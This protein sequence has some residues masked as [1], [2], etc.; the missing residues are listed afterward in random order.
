MC[1]N[2]YILTHLLQ[3]ENL[4]TELYHLLVPL[5]LKRL[6]I[7]IFYYNFIPIAK[8]KILYKFLLSFVTVGFSLLCS[9][10]CLVWVENEINIF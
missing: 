8:T 9:H 1:Q 10:H 4:N 3:D 5:K 2:D 7:L 6:T